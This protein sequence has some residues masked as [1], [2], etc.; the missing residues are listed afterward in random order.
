MFG[1]CGTG[2]ASVLLSLD[3]TRRGGLNSV[4]LLADA[5]LRRFSLV[6]APASAFP[7]EL[8]RSAKDMYSVVVPFVLALL[9]SLELLESDGWSDP[10]AE[11]IRP[12]FRDL[13]QISVN[14]EPLD[15]Q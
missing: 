8:A 12:R 3:G 11:D 7:E 14:E 15:M 10:D 6:W 2:P 13:E 1:E 4:F 5:S 9:E